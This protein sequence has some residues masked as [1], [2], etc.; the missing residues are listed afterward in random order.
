MWEAESSDLCYVYRI[1]EPQWIYVQYLSERQGFE[2]EGTPLCCQ[3]YVFCM[4][5][6]PCLNIVGVGDRTMLRFLSFVHYVCCVY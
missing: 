4:V 6:V 2:E 1:A 5:L 3:K